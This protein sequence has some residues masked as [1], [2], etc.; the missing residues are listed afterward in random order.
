MFISE[1]LA[2]ENIE[3]EIESAKETVHIGLKMESHVHISFSLSYLQAKVL[4]EELLN[5][6]ASMKL[7]DLAKINLTGDMN[8]NR[9]L[10]QVVIDNKESIG[11]GEE[12][13]QQNTLQAP[14][15]AA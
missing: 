1:C 12:I 3:A 10:E 9:P 11:Q 7:E 8:V 15:E 14:T 4:G 13:C 2:Y 5:C 6:T